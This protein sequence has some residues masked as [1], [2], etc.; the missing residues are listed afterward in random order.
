MYSARTGQVQISIASAQ[1]NVEISLII[2]FMIVSSLTWSAG[3]FVRELNI[4]GRA[5]C[6]RHR[7]N[8]HRRLPRALSSYGLKR[9]RF[10]DQRDDFYQGASGVYPMRCRGIRP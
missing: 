5:L 1:V 8:G 3:T 2:L 4:S 10:A 9:R 7:M 6:F